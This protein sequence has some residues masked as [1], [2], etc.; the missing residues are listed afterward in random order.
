MTK[1]KSVQKETYSRLFVTKRH[2]RVNRL[3]SKFAKE[4]YKQNIDVIFRS[5][6]TIDN[7]YDTE[8]HFNHTIPFQ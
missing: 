5:K 2:Q 1:S 3:C 8:F 4:K 7:L 6:T